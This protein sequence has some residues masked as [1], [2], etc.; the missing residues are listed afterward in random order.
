MEERYLFSLC[1]SILGVGLYLLPFVRSVSLWFLY[2]F[3]WYP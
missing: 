1:P 3:P 2:Y